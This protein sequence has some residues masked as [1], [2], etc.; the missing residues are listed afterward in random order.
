MLNFDMVQDQQCLWVGEFDYWQ[1]H[2]TSAKGQIVQIVKG[3]VGELGKAKIYV[4]SFLKIVLALPFSQP[5]SPRKNLVGRRFCHV[6]E[7]CP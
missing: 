1:N 6:V 3:R 2:A 4:H 7:S 5:V